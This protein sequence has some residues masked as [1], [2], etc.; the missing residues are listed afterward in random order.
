MQLNTVESVEHW[1][2]QR[3]IPYAK[4]ARTHDDT[5]VSQIA[6]SIAEFGFVNPILVG[7]DNVI[8]AGH[9]RLM[10]AQQLGLDTVPVIV[11]HHLTEAQRRALVIADNKIAENAGWN[12]EL[13]KLELEEL[14]DLGFDLDVI[15]FS[16]EEL[17][18]LLGNDE[19]PGESDEDEIPEVEDEPVSRHGDVWILGDHRLLC[20]DS[21]NKQDLD[22]LMSGE[23]ADMA[24]TDPPYNVDYGN[25]AKDKMRGKDRRIMNDNLGDDFYQ[26]LKDALTNLLS[27]TKGACYIA[28]SSSEL[29]ILQK[30]FRDAGGKWSTFIVWAKNTFTLGRSDYQR[31]YEP[32]LYG[33]REGNG[34][35]WCGAR[36]QGDVWFFNKPVKNDLHPTMKPV[37]LVERAL[38]NSS[39]SRDIVLDLFGGS[40]STL[41]ACEKTGR[42]ARLIELDPNYV[43]VIVRRWQDYSGEKAIRESDELSFDEVALSMQTE[44]VAN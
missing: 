16:D 30:A 19:Q 27:V 11:L 8:I 3:L 24:F 42:A 13:L 44:A 40:G 20:G 10:A 39:K 23:L 28:M 36:D 14:G 41:I 29:D 4:N 37:E 26:F 9:G 25:N 33:W 6:G 2:L 34:H 38:R 31:Q 43:D 12:D 7:D 35:F 18:E 22:K 5:Q 21:T 17:D 32:I 1:S 15:G